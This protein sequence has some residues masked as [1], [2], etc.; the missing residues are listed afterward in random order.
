MNGKE[1]N[2]HC[3][4]A[5]K[6]RF[7]WRCV[8]GTAVCLTSNKTRCC[9]YA[10]NHKTAWDVS[11][12]FDARACMISPFPRFSR[13]LML[14]AVFAALP[15]IARASIY[16]LDSEHGDDTGNGT[17]A[18]APW[19]SLHKINATKLLPGDQVLFDAAASGLENCISGMPEPRETRFISVPTAT[20]PTPGRRSTAAAMSRPRSR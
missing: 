20:R 11:G 15:T 17:S 13:C 7:N 3:L 12:M 18:A 9:S 19:K 6:A 16:Y 5:L 1:V 8:C 2:A 14:C 4:A 10:A